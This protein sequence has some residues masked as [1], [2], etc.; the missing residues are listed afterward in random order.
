MVR[1]DPVK[2][3]GILLFIL[4]LFFF[5]WA[6]QFSIHP[7]AGFEG[8]YINTL[9]IFELMAFVG[10]FIFVEQ[11]FFFKETLSKVRKASFL[12]VLLNVLWLSLG[13]FFL[14]L[15]ACI[16]YKT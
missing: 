6:M 7:E 14:I 16:S 11:F 8:S 3:I 13:V 10:F 12:S 15:G 4:Y 2:S 9:P 5:F 1:S